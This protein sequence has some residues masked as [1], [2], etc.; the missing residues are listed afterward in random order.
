MQP[1]QVERVHRVSGSTGARVQTFHQPRRHPRQQKQNQ[2]IAETVQ[3]SASKYGSEDDVQAAKDGINDWNSIFDQHLLRTLS[4]FTSLD[5]SAYWFGQP[6]SLFRLVALS[7][8]AVPAS[9]APVWN[10]FFHIL[11]LFALLKERR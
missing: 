6:T 2:K 7:V 1:T 9:S 11:D 8:L 10:D 5:A 3:F 4:F